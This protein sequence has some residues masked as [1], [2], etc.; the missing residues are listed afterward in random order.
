MAIA[1]LKNAIRIFPHY[2]E[3]YNNLGSFLLQKKDYDSAEH[4]FKIAIQLRA[5]YGK[6]YL[7]LGR[8]YLE[9]NENEKAWDHFVKATEGDLDNWAGFAALGE[10]ATKIKK[11][12]EA[13]VAFTQSISLLKKDEAVNPKILFALA[14]SYYM[15]KE[16]DKSISL[17][18]QLVKANPKHNA[19]A[20]NLGEAYFTLENYEQSLK[21]FNI[22]KEASNSLPQ[23]HFR[24]VSC[25][26]KLNRHDDA[27]KYLDVLVKAQAPD[28]FVEK[29]KEEMAQYKEGTLVA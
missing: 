24:I 16:F 8:L 4:S 21:A 2:P 11:Y 18:E 3:A 28:W 23:S 27:Q 25:L 15:E 26:Q 12:K 13:I 9:K 14:N 17:Y 6:A 20:Y 5:H 22:A 19:Y 10:V 7:N 1:A 29:A